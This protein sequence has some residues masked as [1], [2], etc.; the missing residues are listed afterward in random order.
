MRFTTFSSALLITLLAVAISAP[1]CAQKLSKEEAKKLQ[2]EL[3]ILAKNPEKFKEQK[4]QFEELGVNENMRNA[5]F[6]NLNAQFKT[7]ETDTKALDDQIIEQKTLLGKQSVIL[8]TPKIRAVYRV[9]IGAYNSI[10]VAQMLQNQLNFEIETLPTG[11]KRYLVGKFT[12]FQEANNLVQKL[13]NTG[14]QAYTVGY[15]DGTRLN[16]LKE[17]PVELMLKQK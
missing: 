12:S 16:N 6:I 2:A 13:R 15:L 10:E 7:Q 4:K 5:K 17:M 1:L 11:M 14:A 9:Q 3:K 8:Q